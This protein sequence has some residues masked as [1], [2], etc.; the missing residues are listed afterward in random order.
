VKYAHPP[1]R[2]AKDSDDIRFVYCIRCKKN[3][4]QEGL[5][6]GCKDHRLITNLGR[7]PCYAEDCNGVK[8]E[9]SD[10]CRRH[11]KMSFWIKEKKLS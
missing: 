3:R 8:M 11:Q 7:E 1:G 10:A 2:R 9:G 5:C 6:L 4:S